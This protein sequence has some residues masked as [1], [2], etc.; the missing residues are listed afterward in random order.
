MVNKY[1][2]KKLMPEMELAG[3][4]LKKFMK[5]RGNRPVTMGTARKSYKILTKK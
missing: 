3:Q 2:R 1:Y 4:E 5:K